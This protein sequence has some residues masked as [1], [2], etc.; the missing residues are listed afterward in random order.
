[1]TGVATRWIP[2]DRH[3][4]AEKQDACRAPTGAKGDWT[5]WTVSSLSL[6]ST[7]DEGATPIGDTSSA[8]VSERARGSVPGQERILSSV[9][10]FGE[11]P[12][13]PQ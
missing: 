12:C 6:V 8:L 4:A 1:M 2:S 13:S 9:E 10:Y 3:C 5:L 7:A 11:Q